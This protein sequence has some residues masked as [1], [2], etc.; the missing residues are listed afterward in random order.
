MATIADI[1]TLARKLV[2]AD[3]TSYT[4]ADLL[5]AINQA[6]E[7]VVGDLIALDKNWNFG[8]TNYTSLPTGLSNLVAATQSYAINSGFLS[9][10]GVSVLDNNSIWNV[11]TPID[12]RAIL[13]SGIDLDEYQKTDGLPA[14][15]AKREGF[16]VLYPAPAAA[17]IT[18]T[19]GL[20]IICQRTADVFTSAQVTT[21]TKT[22]GF[23]SPYHPILSYKAA[24]PYAI[25]YKPERVPAII[26]E[27]NRLERKLKE[28]Y[29]QR[30]KDERTIITNSYISF[31]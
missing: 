23:A 26:S 14:E 1:N 29:A 19:N 5:I 25:S 24:L 3:T 22:P 6:Y 10:I 2:D 16:V 8:D 11:L 18:A 9:V 20:K 12:E 4:A 21:G 17:N 7:E 13:D 30:A 31:R 28:F 27:I 15:Y